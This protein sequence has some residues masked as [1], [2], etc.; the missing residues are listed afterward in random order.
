MES[1]GN[2]S[3]TLLGREI[4]ITSAK[5]IKG[6]LTVGRKV[7]AFVRNSDAGLTALVVQATRI[8]GH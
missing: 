8:M 2:D 4:D 7:R 6:N 1:V 5:C 3:I